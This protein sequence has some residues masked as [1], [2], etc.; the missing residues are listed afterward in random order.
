VY[1]APDSHG[2]AYPEVAA[3]PVIPVH[4]TLNRAQ[5]Y[6]VLAVVASGVESPRKNRVGVA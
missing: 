6:Y 1:C 2:A 3:S 5:P 4:S